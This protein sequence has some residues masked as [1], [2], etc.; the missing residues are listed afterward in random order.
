MNDRAPT[1]FFKK[2]YDHDWIRSE[3]TIWQYNSLI[4][5]CIIMGVSKS[6][7]WSIYWVDLNPGLV[8]PSVGL[9][10]RIP[11]PWWLGAP[12]P[13]FMGSGPLSHRVI[14]AIAVTWTKVHRLTWKPKR[15]DPLSAASDRKPPL[16]CHRH[17][18]HP[19]HSPG[20][21]DHSQTEA[22]SLSSKCKGKR[23]KPCF[24]S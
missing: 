18:T 4:P 8:K 24:V 13:P 14:S 10:Y 7:H 2:S 22:M 12:P 15:S 23:S 17:H 6:I 19:R 9:P 21:H 11:W 3:N 1:F 5:L 16:L 20:A